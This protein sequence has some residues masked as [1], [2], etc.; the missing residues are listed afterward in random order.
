MKNLFL[1]ISLSLALLMAVTTSCD[2]GFEELNVDP[3]VANEIDPGFQF[4]YIL[5]QTSGESYENWRAVL[6]YSAC[7]IQH[8]AALPTYWSGDKYLYNAEYTA[9]LF[10]RAYVNQVRDIIDLKRNL[11]QKM[12]DGEQVAN[13]LAAVKIWRAVIFMRMTDLYGD[14]PYSEAGLGFL[15]GITTPKYDAQAD[16]YADMIDE[17]TEAV[18]MFDPAQPTFGSADIIY[19]GDV[20]KWKKFGNS[21]LLRLGLRLS[22]VNPGKAQETVNKAISGGVMSDLSETAFIPHTDGPEGIN[23]NGIGEV[24]QQDNN[25]HLS[26][27]FVDWMRD[28]GDPRL[29]IFSVVPNGGD[30]KGLPNGYD[31]TTI[32]THPNTVLSADGS[33]DMSQFSDVNPVI[34]RT[35]SPMIFQSYA[36]VELMLAEAAVRGWGGGDAATHYNNGVRAAMKQWGEFFDP[37]TTIDDAAIDAYLAANP[38]DGTLKM[39][40]DQYWAATFMNEYEAYNN[41]R[42]TGYP[43]LTPVQYADALPVTNGQIPL[44]LS[45]PQSES[46]F[47]GDN[48]NEALSRQGINETDFSKFLNYPVWWDK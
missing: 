35:S 12:A 25:Q 10:D 48:L 15:E 42:R 6:I 16:I 9:S 20:D 19:G 11:E 3:N 30:H 34:V 43:E 17:I 41:W 33:V 8:L 2:E 4:T 18:A 31:A 45:Y 38:F 22:E 36:E 40:A 47:N 29:D 46:A 5:L 44:R 21:L 24:W 1:K 7:M 26:K 37:S 13:L 28:H 23:R 14:I 27:T 39:V 32:S